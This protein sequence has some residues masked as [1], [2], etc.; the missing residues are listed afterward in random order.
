MPTKQCE[1]ESDRKWNSGDN[2]AS[3]SALLGNQEL[4]R[5]SVLIFLA[6]RGEEVGMG[7]QLED[8][9]QYIDC[10]NDGRGDAGNAE[11]ILHGCS[12]DHG[13]RVCLVSASPTAIQ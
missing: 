8:E 6:L 11:H 9:K 3:A 5:D 12:K 1:T 4:G 13:S 10:R 7:K 2:N